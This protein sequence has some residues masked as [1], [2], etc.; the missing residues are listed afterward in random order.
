MGE[1]LWET[2]RTRGDS[3][4][5]G[6]SGQ[7]CP[8]G[9][10]HRTRI[11]LDRTLCRPTAWAPAAS[12]AP[13][14][15]GRSRLGSP[16]TQHT[17]SGMIRVGGITGI[18]K[19]AVAIGNQSHQSLSSPLHGHGSSP[20]GSR[21][22]AVPQSATP[23]RSRPGCSR[24]VPWR[25]SP[26]WLPPL[27]LQVPASPGPPVAA[28]GTDPTVLSRLN[29]PSL[30][31]CMVFACSALHGPCTA[32]APTHTSPRWQPWPQGGCSL[33]SRGGS[34]PPARLHCSSAV[35]AGPQRCSQQ[36]TQG[37]QLALD[38]RTLTPG[39]GVL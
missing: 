24:C 12:T 31:G 34:A 9:S 36:S 33:L 30:Q 1:G 25:S 8:S 5:W 17:L 35:L 15:R 23:D 21:C 11:S 20:P 27:P 3:S 22:T 18:T 26:G 28:A 7:C 29:L 37:P 19:C 2:H 10:L 39:L 4:C 14:E 16:A 13:H 38:L 6:C 32:G